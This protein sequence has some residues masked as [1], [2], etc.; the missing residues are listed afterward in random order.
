MQRLWISLALLGCLI[1][2]TVL[3]LHA[4]MR[5]AQHH[6]AALLVAELGAICDS[7]NPGDMTSERSA[8]TQQAPKPSDDCEVCKST[9][10]FQFAIVATVMLGLCAESARTAF[11]LPADDLSTTFEQVEPRSRGPPQIL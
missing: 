2:A 6:N 4:S 11:A 7:S 3:P 10:A 1:Q 8:P 5:A 9:A